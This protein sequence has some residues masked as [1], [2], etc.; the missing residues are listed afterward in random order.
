M[1]RE[2]QI[3]LLVDVPFDVGER[4]LDVKEGGGG[5][6]GFSH[7]SRTLPRSSTPAP[8]GH[9]RSASRNIDDF[10]PSSKPWHP[11]RLAISRCPMQIRVGY[12]L[13]YTFPQP[14]PMILTLNIHY[15]RA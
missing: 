8:M 13:L 11:R 1:L 2:A 15:S 6:H 4:Q 9:R 12:E 5:D 7:Q 14:T 3:Q 10:V